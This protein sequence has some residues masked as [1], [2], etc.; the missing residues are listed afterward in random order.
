MNNI[1]P[2]PHSFGEAVLAGLTAIWPESFLHT[3]K[4]ICQ[5]CGGHYVYFSKE[6]R[7]PTMLR[8]FCDECKD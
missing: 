4:I 6:R 5:R 8:K 1:K 2:V 7:P 3:N